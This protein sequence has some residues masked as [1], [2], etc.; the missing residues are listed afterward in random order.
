[1]LSI[2]TRSELRRRPIVAPRTLLTPLDT[3]DAPELWTSVESSRAYLEPWLPWVPFQTDPPSCMRFIEACMLDWDHGYALRFAIRERGS[4]AFLGVISL[5]MIQ[6]LNLSCDMGY[7]LRKDVNGRGLMTEVATATAEW[8]FQSV[9]LHRIR[10]AAATDNH[11]SLSV[12]RRVGFRFEGIARHA[13]FVA[14]RWLDHAIFAKLA[15]D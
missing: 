13:E 3:A 12:I 15:T 9:G 10:V 11:R 8:G 2:P 14:G 5:D 1:M 6:H 7:W 4:Q